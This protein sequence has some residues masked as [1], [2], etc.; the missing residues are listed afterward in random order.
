MAYGQKMPKMVSVPSLI[1]QKKLDEGVDIPQAKI[2]IL[3]YPVTSGRELVQAV[4]RIVRLNDG[5]KAYVLDTSNGSNEALWNNFKK[6]DCSLSTEHGKKKFLQS[7]DTAGLIETYI[8]NFPEHVYTGSRFRKK[9]DFSDFKPESDL[10]IPSTSVCFLNKKRGFTL[11]RFSDS[12]KSKR[13]QKG[14]L[15]KQYSN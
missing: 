5:C 4:G 2:L 1:H 8:N 15:V 14:E 6:F 13:N 10:Q 3:T 7:L 12:L 11:A 9:F